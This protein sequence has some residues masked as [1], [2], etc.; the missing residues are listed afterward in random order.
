MEWIC[1]D[2]SNPTMNTARY[3]LM[4]SAG[5]QTAGIAVGGYSYQQLLILQQNH[6]MDL[7]GQVYQELNTARGYSAGLGT[8]T[9]AL[10]A[11]GQFSP[12]Y[13]CFRIL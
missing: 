8:Q 1:L 2:N 10:I 13:S 3:G 5:T 9:S 11:G 7:L 6:L 4:G 12:S